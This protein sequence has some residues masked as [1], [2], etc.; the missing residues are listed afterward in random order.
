MNAEEM[1]DIVET[2]LFIA[3]YPLP[4]KRLVEILG[5]G[6]EAEIESC[7]RLL[8]KEHQDRKSPLQVVEVAGGFQMATR[9]EFGP[10]VRKLYQSKMTAR[11]SAA[12]L[13]TLSIIA[14][15][16][17][18]TRAEVEEI[19]GVE[20]VSA[21]E[22]LLEKKLIR[23]AGRKEAIGRPLLYETTPEFLR[24]FGLRALEDMPNL[25]ALKAKAL[26]TEEAAEASAQPDSPPSA[27]DTGRL[28]Q[29]SGESSS[30]GTSEE[31]A[32]PAASEPSAEPAPQA[33]VPEA[34]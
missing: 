27:G 16:Q 20:A 29:Q 33:S 3:E 26:E 30:P 6:T 25:E 17:P 22:R 1:K 2:L 28:E 15:R 23:I 10:W 31:A 5:R 32:V 13:E 9:P 21:L 24:R 11:L 19:R 4:L 34:K 18:I 14:Y 7:V 12:S 8:Q